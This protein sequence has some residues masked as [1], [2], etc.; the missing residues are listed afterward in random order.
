M[1]ECLN[2]ILKS[3][4]FL[5][6]MSKSSHL[7]KLS[8]INLNLKIILNYKYFIFINKAFQK[9]KSDTASKTLILNIYFK[10]IIYSSIKI[11]LCKIY[12]N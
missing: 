2:N 10:F 7:L 11:S 9:K 3:Q 8:T 6:I 4:N 1:K 12:Y 5:E